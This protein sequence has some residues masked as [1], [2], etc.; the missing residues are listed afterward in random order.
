MYTLS[1]SLIIVC[2]SN[3]IR[4]VSDSQLIPFLAALFPRAQMYTT[5]NE[6]QDIVKVIM[7][8]LRSPA[9]SE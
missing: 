8:Q 1:Y 2:C 3:H 5:R 9:E 6:A 7:E 4:D